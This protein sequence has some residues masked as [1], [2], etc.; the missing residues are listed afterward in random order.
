MGREVNDKS[1]L[2]M[3]FKFDEEKLENNSNLSVELLT[4][5]LDDI[6]M[7]T[8]FVKTGICE[9]ELPE[10]ESTVGTLLILSARF[11]KQSWLYPNLKSWKV[12]EDG[13]EQDALRIMTEEG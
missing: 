6:C 13:E 12:F 7:N 1:M 11:D 10:D 2:K 4:A 5:L 8:R 9:Y 3:K